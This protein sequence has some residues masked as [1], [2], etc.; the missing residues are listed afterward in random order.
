MG[1]SLLIVSRHQ[2]LNLLMMKFTFLFFAN[3][4][5]LFLCQRRSN[6]LTTKVKKGDKVNK[7]FFSL[8]LC[9]VFVFANLVTLPFAKVEALFPL[10]E[11]VDVNLSYRWRHTRSSPLHVELR[12]QSAR[13][14]RSRQLK[15]LAS[16]WLNLDDGSPR[17]TVFSWFAIFLNRWRRH[18]GFVNE[19]TKK[20]KKVETKVVKNG[21][22]YVKYDDDDRFVNN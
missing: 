22:V 7:F 6:G 14:M 5:P 10:F 18:R 8:S 12:I 13:P 15:M 16:D 11:V 2:M 9:L 21:L 20:G 4:R 19:L 3:R 17:G 1:G